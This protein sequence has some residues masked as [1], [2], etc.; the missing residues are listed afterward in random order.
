MPVE[1]FKDEEAYRR[2]NAYRHMHGIPAP[3][4]ETVVVGG[5][6]HK[7]KHSALSRKR[8]RKREAKRARK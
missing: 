4:R 7:V 8:G 5:K 1:H 2:S 6:R 3:N